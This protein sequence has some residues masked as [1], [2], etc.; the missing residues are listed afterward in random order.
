MTPVAL[1][2][3][4]AGTTPPPSP[5]ATAKPTA[6][7]S[8]PVTTVADPPASSVES[9]PVSSLPPVSDDYEI[10]VQDCQALADNFER[11]LR[12]DEIAE[13]EAKKFKGKVLERA[14]AQAAQVA[15]KG[16]DNWHKACQGI[17]GSVRQRSRL[18]CALKARTR[19]RFEGC[20]DGK[21]DKK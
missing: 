13:V 18:Q 10:T 11:V 14:K 5:A 12:K 16:A 7:A 9:T 17:V 15:R 4:G 1:L 3:C 20:M 8:A 6:T 21:F 19:Q 2:A